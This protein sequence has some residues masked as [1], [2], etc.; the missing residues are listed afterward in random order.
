LL[1]TLESIDVDVEFRELNRYTDRCDKGRCTAQAFILAVHV[2]TGS[3]LTFC[4]HHGKQVIPSL[5]AQNFVI[6][7]ETH[8]I[9]DKP[10]ISASSDDE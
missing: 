9:N 2:D 10:S 3:E 1:D 8:K 4:G 7:D 6:S 5:I